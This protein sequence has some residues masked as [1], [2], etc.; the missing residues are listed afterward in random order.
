MRA[1]DATSFILRAAT[2]GAVLGLLA[3][4]ALE[5]ARSGGP[6]IDGGYRQAL[7]RATP[8][9]VSVYS[10]RRITESPRA[11]SP[12]FD[13]FFGSSG[14]ARTRTTL[15]SGVVLDTH[16][17]VVTNHH[18]IAGAERVEVVLGDGRRLGA[19]RVGSDPDTDL[20]LLQVEA[21]G[22]AGIPRAD[23]HSLARGD[24][25]LAIGNPWGVGQAATLGIVGA[26]GRGRLGLSTFE[27]FI[28]H[29]AAINPGSSGGALVNPRG[30]LVGINTAIFSRSGGSH[31]IGFAIPLDLVLE[32]TQQLREHGRVIRGWLGVDTRDLP[33]AEAPAESPGLHVEGV[34]ADGPAER[35]GLRMGD[36]LLAINGMK[37]SNVEAL[38]RATTSMHPGDRVTVTY[39]RNGEEHTTEAVLAQRPAR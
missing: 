10:E 15:G 3:F 25:V 26:T 35:A 18:V 6:G 23:P 5:L 8:A 4:I 33:A 11:G 2:V 31:G 29:D 17:H 36:V 32:V 22:L 21:D 24:V 1:S 14:G 28:Q 20:A 19:S 27:D 13:E 39:R 38:L 37:L 30:E 34:F 16:G 12:L 7:A 9:V